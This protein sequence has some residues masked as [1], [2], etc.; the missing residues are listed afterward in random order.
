MGEEFD[1]ELEP[2]AAAP[3]AEMEPAD[4]V[5]LL[6]SVPERVSDL[7]SGLSDGQLGYR[8]GPAFPTAAEVAEHL[9]LTGGGLDAT[10]TAVSLDTEP[11]AGPS[12][13]GLAVAAQLED[14]QRH[15]R[16]AA[17]LLRGLPAESWDKPVGDVTLVE[18]CRQGLRH[19][20]GHLT[21]LRNLTALL[22]IS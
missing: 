2:V 8:H 11:G 16:R 21:Q 22:P 20:L 4:I 14:W 9:A 3:P 7:V 6:L 1:E 13:G 15:R 10:V 17:D 19:E 5:M 18:Y 12:L